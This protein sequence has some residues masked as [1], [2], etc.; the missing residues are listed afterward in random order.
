MIKQIITF[1]KKALVGSHW[2]LG[3]STSF[4]FGS[5]RNITNI[6]TGISIP[7]AIPISFLPKH[8]QKKQKNMPMMIPIKVRN[9]PIPIPKIKFLYVSS[10]YAN[11]IANK[12]IRIKSRIKF[13]ILNG[14]CVN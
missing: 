14:I 8:Y 9:V 1:T 3:I 6:I 11:E 7:I 5:T 13:K 12:L 10:S 2:S 4:F